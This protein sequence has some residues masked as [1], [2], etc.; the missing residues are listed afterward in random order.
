MSGQGCAGINP[1]NVVVAEM[2]LMR[3][4]LRGFLQGSVLARCL[5]SVL[6][7]PVGDDYAG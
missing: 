3:R 5:Q 7:H 2:Q 6:F 4:L 1:R